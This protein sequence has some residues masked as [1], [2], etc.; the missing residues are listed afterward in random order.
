MSSPISFDVNGFDDLYVSGQSNCCGAPVYGDTDICTCCGE[1][2][3]V[4]G[5]G[6][7]ID[8]PSCDGQGVVDEEIK[9]SFASDR[10]SPR[11]KKVECN[12]CHGSGVI[13]NI[14]D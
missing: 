7:L 6:D 4:E 12:L 1:H 9:E 10:I 2:C 14:K 13:E 3:E 5:D 8:C 11:Y